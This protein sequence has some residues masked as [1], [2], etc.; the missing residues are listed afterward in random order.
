MLKMN[1]T[2]KM[3]NN[4]LNFYKHII[5][6]CT[7]LFSAGIV[8]AQQSNSSK[9]EISV[10]IMK[11][12][13]S[14]LK[15]D[16]DT[17]GEQD[18]RLGGGLGVQYALYLSSN[19]SVSAGAEYQQYHSETTF[20]NFEG[21]YSTT[22]MEGDNFEFRSSASSYQ[23]KQ[24]LDMLNIPLRIQFETTGKSTRF[25]ASTGIQW[26]IPVQTKYKV[27]ATNLKTSGYYE[28]YDA[29]LESPAFMGFGNWGTV[30]KKNQK[31]DIKN[32]FSLLFELG[33]KQQVKE[34]ENLYIG[35][36]AE[37]G[38]NE[39]NKESN[40][41]KELISYNTENPT[42][43]Q[44]ESITNASPGGQGKVYADKLKTMGFGLKVRYALPW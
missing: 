11:G 32:S 1:K 10:Y 34:N 23:E 26:G 33:I 21:F 37:I 42:E 39:L 5:L 18:G 27:T 20:S 2:T 6:S 36:Y 14:Y 25:F 17:N 12:G 22:D 28:Q 44:F 3:K 13:V 9:K 31:L 35:L 24:L 7:L 19:W 40:S 41:S 29:L 15:Y 4:R 43:F 30:V 16:M 38:L 8:T